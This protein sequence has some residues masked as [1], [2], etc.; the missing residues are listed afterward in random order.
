LAAFSGIAKLLFQIKRKAAPERAHYYMAPENDFSHRNCPICNRDTP[1]ATVASTPPAE[2]MNLEE[3]TPYW[4]GFFKKKVFFSYQRCAQCQLLYCPTFFS[5]EQLENLY[6]QMPDNTAGIPLSAMQRTQH[7]YFRS[8]KEFSKLDG[9][10]LETGPDIG[11]FTENCINE[12]N[13]NKYWLFEPNREVWPQLENVTSGVETHISPEMFGFSSVPDKAVSAAV[14]IH[15]LD[16][17]L[18]PLT[19]LQK[20]HEKLTSNAILIVVTHDE[21]SLLAK[22]TKAGWPAY[23]L[24][25]PQLYNPVS[26]GKLMNAAGFKVLDVQKTANYFPVTYLAKH[27]LWALGMRM[28]IPQV[29]ALQLPLKLGN[30]LTVATP[31]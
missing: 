21:S 29:G 19:I 22:L 2:S 30:I 28:N 14:M 20:L 18:D 15:V 27:L 1:E 16:H 17:L 25:H 24:Q 26:I 4:N 7:G 31:I 13:F 23:C 8:L 11:L 5:G 3:L 9:N 10:Y 6:K 12:G